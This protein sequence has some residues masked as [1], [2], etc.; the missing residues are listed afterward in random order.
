MTQPFYAL[1][2]IPTPRLP[3]RRKIPK[4]AALEEH[5]QGQQTIWNLNYKQHSESG[6]GHPNKDCHANIGD[7]DAAEGFVD[8]WSEPV[9]SL[10][11]TE[12]IDNR[13]H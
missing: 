7:E 8:R 4:S 1:L 3:R 2:G 10:Q 9:P 12:S 6:S 5:I 11:L 13:P